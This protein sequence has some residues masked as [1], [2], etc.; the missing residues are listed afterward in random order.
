M[1]AVDD[2]S[3]GHEVVL[4]AG[5]VLK[6]SLSQNASTGYSWTVHVKPEILRESQGES[7]DPPK[8]P[9][10]SPGVRHFY[11]EALGQGSG[12]LELEYRRSWEQGV[13][14]ARMFKLRVQVQ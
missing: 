6:I 1:I 4:H 2:S 11:F 14:P 10:G 8:G 9:P 7:P 13:Q 12:E 3:N 5:E